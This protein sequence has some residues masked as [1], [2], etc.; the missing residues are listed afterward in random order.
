MSQ[1]LPHLHWVSFNMS[2]YWLFNFL[3]ESL[4]LP[5]QPSSALVGVGVGCRLLSALPAGE[6]LHGCALLKDNERPTVHFRKPAA[7]CVA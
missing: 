5:L 4:Y 3:N 7:L 6:L 2:F 1:R